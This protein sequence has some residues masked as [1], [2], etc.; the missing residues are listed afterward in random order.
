MKRFGNNSNL[1]RKPVAVLKRLGKE[2]RK[3]KISDQLRKAES[4]A[5]KITFYP[6]VWREDADGEDTCLQPLFS[7]H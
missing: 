3:N 4:W 2:K 7:N 6:V 5:G 1:L